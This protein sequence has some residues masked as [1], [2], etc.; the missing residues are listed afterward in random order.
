LEKTIAPYIKELFIVLKRSAA[1][2]PLY[3]FCIVFLLGSKY[4][5]S[6]IAREATTLSLY[7]RVEWVRMV[8][9]SIVIAKSVAVRLLI[10]WG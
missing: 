1:D 5:C 3:R 10:M 6:A 4:T 7:L 9:F 2:R 8:L